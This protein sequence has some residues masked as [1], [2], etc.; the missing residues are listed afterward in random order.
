VLV[1]AINVSQSSRTV[2]VLSKPTFLER[3]LYSVE[4]TQQSECERP[5]SILCDRARLDSS[6]IREEGG[7]RRNLH[8]NGFCSVNIES[9][10]VVAKLFSPR[11]E[12]NFAP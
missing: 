1:V 3:R 9:I 12:S 2:V 10:K 7:R 4:T 8:A 11:S 5:I 6:Q